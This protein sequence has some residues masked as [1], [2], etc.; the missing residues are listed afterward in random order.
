M[1]RITFRLDR[2]NKCLRISCPYGTSESFIKEKAEYFF[3]RLISRNQFASPINGDNVYL[4]GELTHIEA[5]SLWTEKKRKEFLK[6]TLLDYLN[7]RVSFY[8]GEMK[9]EKPYSVKVRDMTSR[10]GVN[11]KNTASLT[12]ALSLVY[13]E[14]STIDSVVVHE[15]AHYFYFDHSSNF[16]AVVYK[17]CPEYKKEHAKLRKHQYHE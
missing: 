14:P 3:P 13:Y 9:I 2:D 4:L 15:L 17:Y 1:R 8:S 11:S 5:F 7:S 16:Y 10:Y 6:K 12:F